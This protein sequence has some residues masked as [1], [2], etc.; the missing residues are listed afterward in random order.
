LSIPAIK[1]N[2]IIQW[3]FSLSL[4]LDFNLC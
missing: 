4:E 2:I 1:R 3:L